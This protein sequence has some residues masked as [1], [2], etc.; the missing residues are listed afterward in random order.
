MRLVCPNCATQYEVDDSAVPASGREVQCGNCSSTWFQAPARS[1]VGVS[2][3]PS[4]L[5]QWSDEGVEI[6]ADVPKDI[7]GPGPEIETAPNEEIINEPEADILIEAGELGTADSPDYQNTPSEASTAADTPDEA[8]TS[9]VGAKATVGAAIGAGLAG[10]AM[11]GDEATDGSGAQPTD[12]GQDAA[13]PSETEN[14]DLTAPDDV[15]TKVETAIRE[16]A[17]VSD[18]DLAKIAAEEIEATKAASRAAEE[19]KAATDAAIRAAEDAASRDALERSAE[20]SASTQASAASAGAAVEDQTLEEISNAIANAAADHDAGN[21]SDAAVGTEPD[22]DSPESQETLAPYEADSASSPDVDDAAEAVAR[23]AEQQTSWL[24]EESVDGAESAIDTDL[25]E[26]AAS[27]QQ[28]GAD[29]ASDIEDTVS[30]QTGDLANELEPSV[31]Q[32]VDETAGEEIPASTTMEQIAEEVSDSVP[33]VDGADTSP[34]IDGINAE[35]NEALESLEAGKP[36]PDDAD[37]QRLSD[38]DLTGTAETP[39]PSPQEVSDAVFQ[40]ASSEPEPTQSSLDKVQQAF[41]AEPEDPMIE[42]VEKDAQIDQSESLAAKLK[43]RVA[44][45]AK[46]QENSNVGTAGLALGASAAGISAAAGRRTTSFPTRDTEDLSSSLRP[47]S[48]EGKTIRPRLRPEATP[49]PAKSRFSQGFLIALALFVTA[50]L[51]YLFRAQIAAVIP[52]L[53]PAL[54]AYA[55]V[56]DQVRLVAQDAVGKLVE[57]VQGLMASFGSDQG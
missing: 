2:E 19:A 52:A 50:L 23:I 10:A 6:A 34:P 44:E 37:G 11:A 35:I 14:V 20:T 28:S 57:A 31:S 17:T 47:K 53:E 56:I 41:E 13:A 46:A 38:Y 26:V 7:P 27:V 24:Q 5:T 39:Q 36:V 45:A 42:A 30:Q 21:L 18:D 16:T 9:G 49:E 32:F 3:Q 33:D 1:N 15:S 43:A 54:T 29:V 40:A 55:G 48:R 12:E 8:P 51:I 4:E 22:V 25:A